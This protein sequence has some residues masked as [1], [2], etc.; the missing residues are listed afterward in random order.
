MIYNEHIPQDIPFLWG[1]TFHQL[2][3]NRNK[4]KKYIGR[5]ILTDLPGEGPMSP[6]WIL[7]RLVSCA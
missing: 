2:S 4:I 7:K 5:H 1:T 6:V 3:K